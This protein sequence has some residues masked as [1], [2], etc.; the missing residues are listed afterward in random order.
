M[1]RVGLQWLQCQSSAVQGQLLLSSPNWLSSSRSWHIVHILNPRQLDPRWKRLLIN[2]KY[3]QSASSP[4]ILLRI[5]TTIVFMV[6]VWNLLAD[7]RFWNYK[8]YYSLEFTIITWRKYKAQCQDSI[9]NFNRYNY[10]IID[11]RYE[12][13]KISA[14]VSITSIC[15]P[16][17]WRRRCG[18]ADFSPLLLASNSPDWETRPADGRTHR[19]RPGDW[20]GRPPWGENLTGSGSV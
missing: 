4:G 12:G 11:N 16:S 7:R 19:D 10:E 14:L 3:C 13:I 6:Q 17:L 8:I 1:R 20:P 2:I 15:S 9:I 18:P 5:S